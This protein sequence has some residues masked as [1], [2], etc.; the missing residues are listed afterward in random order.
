[1]SSITVRNIPESVK[2]ALARRAEETGESLEAYLR[3]ILEMESS[4]DPAPDQ[5]KL[6]FRAILKRIE[7]LPPLEPG[8]KDA[9]EL[10]EEFS[11]NDTPAVA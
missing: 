11:R 3:R 6:R 9:W 8:Q 2:A 10:S 1:M 4:K 5:A 7:E